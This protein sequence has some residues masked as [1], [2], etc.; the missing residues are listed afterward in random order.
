MV[1]GIQITQS[2][3]GPCKVYATIKFK[4]KRLFQP[5]NNI[6]EELIREKHIAIP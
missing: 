2:S 3:R 1:A 6:V 5:F 4:H